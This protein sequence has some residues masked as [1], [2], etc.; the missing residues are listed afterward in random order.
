MK[1]IILI[2]ITILTISCGKEN[3]PQP[4]VTTITPATVNGVDV[5]NINWRLRSGKVFVTNQTNNQKIWYTHFGTSKTTSNLDIFTSSF[6]N[7]DN[8]IQNVTNWKFTSDY[9]FVLDNSTSYDYTVNSLGIVR[10]YGL[11]NGSARV[12]QILDAS[13]TY[14][15]V[16]IYDSYGNDGINNY[17]FYSVLTFENFDSPGY[18][19]DYPVGSEWTSGGVITTNNTNSPPL[20]GTK[21]VVT[22]YVQN[23]VTT[24][25]SDTLTFVSATQYRIGNTYLRNYSL[26]GIVGNNMRSLSLYS[27]TTL[28]GDWS[29][30]VQSTFITDWVINSSLF[31]NLFNSSAPDTRIWMTRIQ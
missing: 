28:G 31:T 18:V 20:Q 8:I 14:L 29:G 19:Q 21:W 30:Q 4:A 24:T 23:F 15:T 9:K 2:L 16:R 3:T 5:T 22:K 12:I 10:V 6:L 7:I 11:Q 1:K 25:T 13:D 27:F 17:S 26:S